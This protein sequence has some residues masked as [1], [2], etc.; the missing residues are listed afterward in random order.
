MSHNASQQRRK[1]LRDNPSNDSEGEY[2]FFYLPSRFH[3]KIFGDITNLYIST[4]IVTN[5]LPPNTLNSM[6]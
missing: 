1:A 3:R 6:L 4:V 5:F 2:F